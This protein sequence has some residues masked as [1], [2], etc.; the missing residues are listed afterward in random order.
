DHYKS[1]GR[2]PRDIELETLA[3]TWSE[4]C[5]HKTLKS[6]VEYTASGGNDTIDWSGRPGVTVNGGVVRINN[7]LKSTVAAATHE[8][9][10]GGVDWALSVF[11][12]NSGVVALDE[13][14]GVC[15][16]V[17]THN[18]PS[19]IEPYGGAATGVGGCIRDVIGTGLGAKPIANTD[20][21][22]VAEPT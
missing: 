13:T 9:I 4:H 12:D 22:C 14:Y 1:L 15:I 10:A 7:L 19:A 11:K 20:V 17:E 8:R 16:K 6:S 5:V 21:F 3:Q 2:E 18:R